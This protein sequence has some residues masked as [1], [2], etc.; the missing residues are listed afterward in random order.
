MAADIIEFNL[1][2]LSN[3]RARRPNIIVQLKIDIAINYWGAEDPQ[4]KNFENKNKIKNGTVATVQKC[5]VHKKKKKKK[6]GL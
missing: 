4:I 1:I 2:L 5:T 6:S 3:I